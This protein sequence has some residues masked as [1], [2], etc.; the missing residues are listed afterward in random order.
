[1]ALAR[2]RSRGQRLGRPK[3]IVDASKFA[4]CAHRATHGAR[5]R[6]KQESAKKLHSGLFLACP[7]TYE[8]RLPTFLAGIASFQDPCL[9]SGWFMGNHWTREGNARR[10]PSLIYAGIPLGV[11]RGEIPGVWSKI[12]NALKRLDFRPRNPLAQQ[13]SETSRT[14]TIRVTKAKT[15]Y[16]SSL[17]PPKPS[18]ENRK[19]AVSGAV[20]RP[21]ETLRQGSGIEVDGTA[22][23]GLTISHILRMLGISQRPP[24]PDLSSTYAEQ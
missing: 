7:K 19:G 22:G 12:S 20:G 4:H 2:A 10:P 9:I 3:K 5:S 8:F 17:C 21:A 14:C 24:G 11:P 6:R 18:V 13:L 1:M 23:D 16:C 15:T